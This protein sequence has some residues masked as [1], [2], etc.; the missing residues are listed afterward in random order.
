M[1]DFSIKKIDENSPFY[2]LTFMKEV[3]KRNGEIASEP[4]DTIYTVSLDLAK[5]IISHQETLNKYH[6]E[7]ISLK[8]YITEFYKSYKEVCELLKKIL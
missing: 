3:H 4:D 2:N 7:D 6:D 8:E 5:S 1:I